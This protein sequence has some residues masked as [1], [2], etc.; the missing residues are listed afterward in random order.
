MLHHFIRWKAHK[1]KFTEPVYIRTK[2]EKLPSWYCTLKMFLFHHP[3]TFQWIS[4]SPQQRFTVFKSW[5]KSKVNLGLRWILGKMGLIWQHLFQTLRK[6]Y[7]GWVR[8]QSSWTMNCSVQW[9]FPVI[10]GPSSPGKKCQDTAFLLQHQANM[11]NPFPSPHNQQWKPKPTSTDFHFTHC[12][13]AI[14]HTSAKCQICLCWVWNHRTGIRQFSCGNKVKWD[15]GLHIW[16]WSI[17]WLAW[18]ELWSSAC[19]GLA[20]GKKLSLI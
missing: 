14:F 3:S 16:D 9:V 12:P 13:Q 20:S 5:R 7:N 6:M 17:G 11:P 2:G 15:Y 18:K 4:P 8:L 19:S 10:L 1:A